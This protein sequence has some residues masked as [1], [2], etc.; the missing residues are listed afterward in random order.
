MA[1]QEAVAVA[2]GKTRYLV[3]TGNDLIFGM[4]QAVM[5][6]VGTFDIDDA[7]GVQIV[8]FILHPADQDALREFRRTFGGRLLYSK[9]KPRTPI[10][11]KDSC[12]E[13]KGNGI[14]PASSAFVPSVAGLIIAS[15]VIKSLAGIN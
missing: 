9:E 8:R 5:T 13:L 15:E 14:A 3:Q 2:F 1:A 4:D 7:V 11:E 12:S 6:A 10:V